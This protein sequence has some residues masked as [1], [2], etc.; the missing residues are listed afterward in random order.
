MIIPEQPSENILVL[1]QFWSADTCAAA[2]RRSEQIGYSMATVQT[3]RGPRRMDF[4]RNNDRVMLDDPLLA[5]RIWDEMRSYAPAVIGKSKAVGPNERF[6]FYRYQPG[7]VFRRHRD[8]SFI[9]SSQEASYY[10]LLIYLNDDFEGGATTFGNLSVVPQCGMAL[11]FLHQL[12]HEGTA[13]TKGVKYVLRTD[14][15]YLPGDA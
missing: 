8:Q 10:T 7:Q 4:L 2:I 9:R 3:E 6:R 1:R 14:I 5:A 11:I 13:V 15:M 12:E